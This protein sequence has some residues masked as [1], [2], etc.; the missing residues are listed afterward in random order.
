EE[1]LKHIHEITKLEN[2]TNQ[3]KEFSEQD[4]TEIANKL[5]E[6]VEQLTKKIENEN[7]SAIRKEIRKERSQLKKSAKQIREDFIPRM[8]KYAEQNETFGD[9]NSYSKTDKDA[10]FMRMK[11]DHMKNGQ[12]KP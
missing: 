9:R 1:T 11:E 12:L 6:K 3:N 7:N 2:E 4:L 10:T 5:D 8:A